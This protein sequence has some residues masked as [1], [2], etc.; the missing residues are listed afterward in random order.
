MKFVAIS[1]THCRHRLLKLPKGDVILHA[2]DISYKGKKA[3]IADFLDWFA[4]LDYKYK[5]FIGGNHDFFLEKGPG[6]ELLNMIPENVIYLCNNGVEIEGIRIWGSPITPWFFN[7]AFNQKR[8]SKIARFWNLIPPG[9]DIV[10]THGPV[11]GILDTVINGKN[12]GCL[13]LFNRLLEIRPKIHLS[14]HIHEGYGWV[15]RFGIRFINASL[16]NEYY[17]LVNQ[18]VVFELKPGGEVEKLKLG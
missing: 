3:E 6:E 2:G 9:T 12:A 11:Y 16:Q 4:A 7:W 17:E 10:M 5:I 1:D 15:K 18:P 13:D 14:G 8:G